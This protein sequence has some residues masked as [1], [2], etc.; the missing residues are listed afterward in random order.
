MGGSVGG[1]VL[2]EKY[3]LEIMLCF[4]SSYEDNILVSKG[5]MFDCSLN[6]GEKLQYFQEHLNVFV[7]ME[8]NCQKY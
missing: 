6:D 7:N 1:I 4:S 8:L 3:M 2:V 5:I